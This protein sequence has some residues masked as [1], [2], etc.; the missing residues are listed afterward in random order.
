MGERLNK[1]TKT[2]SINNQLIQLGKKLPNQK[3]PVVIT[4]LPKK[5][6][7][8]RI[9]IYK[10][11]TAALKFEIVSDNEVFNITVDNFALPILILFLK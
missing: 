3:T 4:Y 1:T 9:S 6:N 5:F 7:G 2:K 11:K 10:N 8:N